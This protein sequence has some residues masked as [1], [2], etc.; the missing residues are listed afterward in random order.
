MNIR[1]RLRISNLLMV[2]VPAAVALAVGIA[3]LACAWVL[4]ASGAAARGSLEVH[5]HAIIVIGA[6]VLIAVVAVAVFAANRFLTAFVL[7]HVTDPLDELVAGV[8]KIRDGDLSVRLPEGRDDEFAP[9]FADFND[10]ARRLAASVERDRR[11]EEE[12]RTLIAGLSHDL[13]SPLTSIQAYAEGLADGVAHTSE[14]RERYLATIVA[15]TAELQRLVRQISLVSKMDAE[16]AS[17][18]LERARLDEAV[19]AWVSCNAGVYA[20]QGVELSCRLAPTE[21]E[22]DRDLLSRVLSN[23]LDNCVKY[24]RGERATCTVRLA[25]EARIVPER[26][27]AAD[28][29]QEGH[30]A[31]TAAAASGARRDTWGARIVVADDGSG[32][33]AE[34]L[35]RLFD[36]FF[37][38][39][40]ARTGT[41]EGNGIGLAVVARAM[42][43]MGGRARAEAAPGDGLAVVLELP[44]AGGSMSGLEA[45]DDG[46]LSAVQ[47]AS[48]LAPSA[49]ADAPAV[50]LASAAPTETV[51]LPDDAPASV[52]PSGDAPAFAAPFVVDAAA[53]CRRV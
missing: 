43:R 9:V 42:A 34:D 7:R 44:L 11:T 19:G 40:P 50:S 49:C 15:K 37:R 38:G 46:G 21:V 31:G 29:A 25:V 36:L 6:A 1:R 22:L 3:M 28:A 51:T 32:V 24:A 30:P 18:H 2:A 35:P 52:I 16:V 47:P 27:A 39:D 14:A 8:R 53:F 33:V 20:A 10:M 41:A 17:A 26:T 23:V 4:V 48:P 5:E 13:R 45:G 12:R